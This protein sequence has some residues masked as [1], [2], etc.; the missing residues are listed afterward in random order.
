MNKQMNEGKNEEVN[1]FIN[2]E[3]IKDGKMAITQVS[4]RDNND[5]VFIISDYTKHSHLPIFHII[6][7]T[8]ALVLT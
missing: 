6:T 2:K 3:I 5:L 8:R 7:R 4:K 1:Q